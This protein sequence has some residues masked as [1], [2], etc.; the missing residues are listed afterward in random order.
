VPRGDLPAVY[1]EHDVLVFPSKW[2]EPFG[3][4]PIEAMACGRSVVGT[5]IGGPPEFVTPTAGVLVDP[6]DEDAIADALVRAAELPLPNLAARAS[7]VEHDVLRQAE[8]VERILVRVVR[9]SR[10]L[11]GGVHCS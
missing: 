2:Q 5:R 7:A 8:R 10:S 11:K 6:T 3:L 9:A 1:G 4:T